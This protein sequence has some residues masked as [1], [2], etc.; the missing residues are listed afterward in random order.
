LVKIDKSDKGE[1]SYMHFT[2][3]LYKTKS[4]VHKILKQ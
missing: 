4:S 2:N 3:V 1:Y